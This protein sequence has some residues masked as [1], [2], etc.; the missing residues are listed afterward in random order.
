M[1]S[2]NLAGWRP[3]CATKFFN[4]HETSGRNIF[5]LILTALEADFVELVTAGHLLLGGVDRSAALWALGRL[6]NLEGHF[7]LGCLFEV[8]KCKMRKF[9]SKY[10]KSKTFFRRSDVYKSWNTTEDGRSYLG[11]L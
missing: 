2:C 8:L 1:Q 11:L 6:W 9:L 3:F 10:Q 5:S 4:H 7:D